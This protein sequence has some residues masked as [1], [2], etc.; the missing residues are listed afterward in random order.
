[1]LDTKD[2]N[3]F[4]TQNSFD[5]KGFLLKVISYWKWFLVSLVVTFLIAY[6]VN[7][8]KEKIYGMESLIVVED[9]NNPL[10]TSNTSLIFNWGGTSDKVQTIIKESQIGSYFIHSGCLRLNFFTSNYRWET[11]H[12]HI[13]P[14]IGSYIIS[15]V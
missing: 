5:F 2:F 7:I 9:Q 4:E 13:V 8:R 1:M 14:N 10:F 11:L 15:L 6:N 3:F 12:I